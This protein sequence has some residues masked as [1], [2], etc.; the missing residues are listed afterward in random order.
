MPSEDEARAQRQADARRANAKR[1]RDKIMANRKERRERWRAEALSL[2]KKWKHDPLFLLGV[3]LYWGEGEKTNS[4]GGKCLALSNADPNLLR[5]WLR[6]CA[7]FVPQ[8]S[9][10]SCLSIHD[11]CDLEAARA[12]WREELNLEIK[13]VS[14]AVSRASKRKRR[15]LPY[16]TLKIRLGRGSL[17]WYTKMLVWLELAHE[18]PSR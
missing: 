5:V 8:V 10:N 3:G 1:G 13:W 2:W 15:T 14:M 9:L 17:E 12:Y 6:W 4:S 11:N 7:R 16:G 18:L